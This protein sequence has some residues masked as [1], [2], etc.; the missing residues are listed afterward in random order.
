[1]AAASACG[2]GPKYPPTN[3]ILLSSYL[4]LHLEH[5]PVAR[6]VGHDLSVTLLRLRKRDDLDLGEALVLG[7]E[8]EHI[9]HGLGAADHGADDLALAA[10][11]VEGFKDKRLVDRG[12]ADETER[13]ARLE[14]RRVRCA[15]EVAR[16]AAQDE[17]KRVGGCLHGV[18]VRRDEN[19]RRAE[20]LGLVRL[21]RA[22][23]DGN[24]V[25]AHGARILECHVSEAADA[26]NA[27]LV[28][29][30]H[31]AREGRVGRDARAEQR[32]ARVERDALGDR[33][34]KVLVNGD[35][36]GVAAE[37]RVI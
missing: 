27:D 19:F 33:E 34:S 24:H 37:F 23:R 30:L 29:R 12:Q 17:V 28:A 18:S 16:R 14:Q 22:R 10:H 7:R 31:V 2:K 6:R 3:L 25:A 8:G 5:H 20:G 15:L 13:L 4:L 36:R 9:F 26:Y 1:M 32:A 21:G 35:G 11:D